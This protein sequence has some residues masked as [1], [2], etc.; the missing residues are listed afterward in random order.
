MVRCGSL[1]STA[2]SSLGLVTLLCI[3]VCMHRAAAFWPNWQYTSGSETHYAITE[4]AILQVLESYF[5]ISNLGRSQKDALGEIC[6]ANTEVDGDQ[7]TARL[8]VDGEALDE[9]QHLILSYKHAAICDLLAGSDARVPVGAALHTLQDFYAHS[10][11]VELDHSTPCDC[12][13]VDGCDLGDLGAAADEITCSDC[14]DASGCEGNLVTDHV[15]TGYYSGEDKVKTEGVKCSH[16]GSTD[17]SADIVPKGGINKDSLWDS[18]SP[19]LTLH[20]LAAD[21]AADASVKFLE[22]I[23]SEVGDEAF[24]ALL[25]VETTLAVAID[26]SKHMAEM[27]ETIKH[28]IQVLAQ[29]RRFSLFVLITFSDSVKLQLS[30]PSVSIFLE[31]LSRITTSEEPSKA[32]VAALFAAS[33][34]A[35][36]SSS[37]FLFTDSEPTDAELLKPLMYST[38]SKLQRLF[39]FAPGA[40]NGIWSKLSTASGG[41]SLCSRAVTVSMFKEIVMSSAT[42]ANTCM[43]LYEPNLSVGSH[44]YTFTVDPTLTEASVTVTPLS[45]CASANQSITVYDPRGNPAGTYHVS[46]GWTLVQLSNPDPGQWKIALNS[47]CPV[48]LIAEGISS[49]GVFF[50]FA[51]DNLSPAH[52]GYAVINGEPLYGYSQYYAI[53]RLHSAQTSILDSLLC[54]LQ[55]QDDSR[56]EL[57]L[58]SD[59]TEYYVNATFPAEPFVFDVYGEVDS[60][61]FSRVFI[62]A[63]FP[64]MMNIAV[65][66]SYYVLAPTKSAKI[67]PSFVS[68]SDS[69][70]CGTVCLT[71][72]IT[73]PTITAELVTPCQL[74]CPGKVVEFDLSV[75][76]HESPQGT[77]AN[78]IL[79]AES[80]QGYSNYVAVQLQIV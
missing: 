71:A 16:G 8:H 78:L 60:A 22:E 58:T 13:G 72:T 11:W 62:W 10:N 69:A 31:E 70:N 25:G 15:T 56:M 9:A 5:G 36:R 66:G 42:S 18:F 2:G 21:I 52:P 45:E 74:T 65:Y 20:L 28:E 57:P 23:R 46:D 50:E 39:I 17:K 24:G 37:L 6:D 27:I 4:T 38:T 19:H 77:V 55:F 33:S 12:L 7:T 80:D 73:E 3:C 54:S 14:A 64:Q 63:G 32:S 79:V 43:L 51:L 1:L 41:T 29:E 49:L 47:D 68:V 30:T 35:P 67:I 53:M 34:R 48:S 75:S 59:G 76:T 40:S 44:N 61:P 26:T